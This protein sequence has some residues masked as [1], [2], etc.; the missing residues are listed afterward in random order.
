MKHA[1]VIVVMLAAAAGAAWHYRE[2]LAAWYRSMT[3]DVQ[4]TTSI[5]DIVAAPRRFDGREVTV[6]GTVTGTS[7]VSFGGGPPARS[8]TLRDGKAEIVVDARGALPLRGQM[9]KVTGKAARP[10]GTGLA[11]RL[12]ETKR[13]SAK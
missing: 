2:D 1:L 7:E 9:L 12:A 10:P 3:G 11:P 5:A 4:T 6:S 13:E 8:Y